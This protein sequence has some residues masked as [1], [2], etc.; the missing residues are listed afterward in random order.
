MQIKVCEYKYKVFLDNY[1]RKSPAEV[2]DIDLY[3]N[4]V[5][6]NFKEINNY[7]TDSFVE[8]F[9]DWVK[10]GYP[11]IT[12]DDLKPTCYEI[13]GVGPFLLG[14]RFKN[15]ARDF[16]F[17]LLIIGFDEKYLSSVINEIKEIAKRRFS[18]IKPHGLT[19]NLRFTYN[20]YKDDIFWNQVVA[21]KY[22][23]VVNNSDLSLKKSD[24]PMDYA[25]YSKIYDHWSLRNKSLSRFVSKEPEAALIDSAKNGLYYKF[26]VK[27]EF[28]GII[29]GRR[30]QF[31]GNKA[32]YIFDELLFEKF[33]RKGLA[34]FMQQLFHLEMKNIYYIYG[35]IIAENQP[36]LKTALACNREII[37]SEVFFSF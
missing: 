37:E 15:G 10:E 6:E 18:K 28:A 5:C 27:N 22:E 9:F 23:G 3:E 13:K 11:D 33:I 7:F 35:H 29:C 21:G 34:K 17:I 12:K 24:T 31:Y 4:E 30:E 2:G 8:G 25:E 1:L 14:Q 26:Y 20:N 36:S 19:V 16:P 32:V